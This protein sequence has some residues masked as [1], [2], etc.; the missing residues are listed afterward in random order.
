M[1]IIKSSDINS[2]SPRISSSGKITRIL[3]PFHGSDKQRSLRINNYTG[4]FYCFQCQEWGYTDWARDKWLAQHGKGEFIPQERPLT[5]AELRKMFDEEEEVIEREENEISLPEEFV[6]L[7]PP[8][9]SYLGLILEKAVKYLFARGLTEEDIEKYDIRYAYKGRYSGRVIIPVCLNGKI[10]GYVGRSIEH[11]PKIRYLNSESNFSKLLF[12]FD[13]VTS[14][15]VIIC[16]GVFDAIAVGGNAVAVFK[17]VITKYQKNLLSKFKYR[18][19]MFDSD[20]IE[21]A[22]KAA[23]EIDAKVCIIPDIG[24]KEDPS[25]VGK[26]GCINLL[27]TNIFSIS[28]PDAFT[29]M[30]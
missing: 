1:K 5:Y 24:T 13:R 16:E 27:K 4:K 9:S 20:A 6:K 2:N 17:K 23:R 21:D 18:I 29:Y 10:Y 15:T 19:V 8:S 25:S 12:N 30:M 7:F 22:F 14:D 11:R 26:K 28:D 3:C